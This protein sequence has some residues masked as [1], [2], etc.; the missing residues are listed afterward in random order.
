M[1]NLT[2][3]Y[4]DKS[5][6]FQRA[7][8]FILS[9]SQEGRYANDK[10]DLG[11][12]TY[13][14]IARKFNPSWD[15][16]Q[17]IDDAKEIFPFYEKE[18]HQFNAYVEGKGILAN[19][20]AFYYD[21]F[22]KVLHLDKVTNERVAIKIFEMSVSLGTPHAVSIV[23]NSLNLMNYGANYELKVDNIIGTITINLI[24][25]L[26]AKDNGELLFDILTIQQGYIYIKL[27]LTNPSQ[28]KFI[29]GWINRLNIK[30]GD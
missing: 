27:A 21:N 12:E 16:W 11:G 14:G 7:L 10:N 20:Q 24:N 28:R 17:I 25:E 3:E 5:T 6:L 23:Q 2:P 19:V 18:K 1:N 13:C 4:K 15:G 30:I 26:T 9:P 29:R 22:W 8:H